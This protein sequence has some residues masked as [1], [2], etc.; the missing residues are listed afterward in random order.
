MFANDKNEI[1]NHDNLFTPSSY[2][3]IILHPNETKDIYFFINLNG[4]VF[5]KI[6]NK[7]STNRIKGWW[8]KGP[9][10]SK[11]DIGTLSNTGSTPFKG[12]IWGRLKAYGADSETTILITESAQVAINFPSINY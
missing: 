5:Y 11:E 7:S 6:V 4:S 10:G 8:L 12:L 3:T 9:F 2:K 1:A